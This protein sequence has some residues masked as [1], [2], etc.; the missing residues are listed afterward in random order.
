MYDPIATPTDAFA[1][2][3]LNH[4][5]KYFLV[6]FVATQLIAEDLNTS[7]EDAWEELVASGDVGASLQYDVDH[8]ALDAIHHE[9]VVSARKEKQSAKGTKLK[10]I[11]Y[12]LD[13]G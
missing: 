10:V 2:L 6:P 12:T 4:F 7:Y 13:P 8:E 5:T 1:P 9:N 11:V 3:S